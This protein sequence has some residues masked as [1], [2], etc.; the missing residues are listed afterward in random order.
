[1]GDATEMNLLQERSIARHDSVWSR[2]R[3]TVMNIA[4]A[5]IAVALEIY[6]SICAGACSYLEGTIFGIGLQ[7]VGI[8][9]MACIILLSI[10]KKDTLLLVLL[11]AGVGIE[12]YLIGFQVWHNTY[13]LYCLAF[14]AI[15]FI[16]F[17]MNFKRDR[18]MLCVVSMVVALIFFS[19][20]FK[21][22]LVPTYSYTLQTNPTERS[23]CESP[24][25]L[26]A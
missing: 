9:Y 17:V 12:F 11:S 1:M 3:R 22:S 5:C 2:H 19:I 7:Y 24:E 14:A 4:L 13:C 18:T 25:P 8:G 6:Y 15:V 21:G 23:L 16:L 26:T 20:F 10:L